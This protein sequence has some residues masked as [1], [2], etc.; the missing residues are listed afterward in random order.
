[1]PLL[2]LS[3]FN[4]VI[5]LLG[6][7]ITLFGLVSYLI[8]E[9]YYLSEAFLSLFA[10][11]LFK[12]TGL[13]KPLEYAGG[14]LE[15]LETVTL[16]FT[17]LVLGVQLV[18][19]G[20]QLPSRYLLK[21][22]RSLSLLLGPGMAGMWASTSLLVYLLVP[23]VSFL[24]ALAIGA[25]VTPTDPLLS[26]TILRG[27]FA[28]E[29]VPE[30]LRN[31]II[32]ESGANDGLGYTFLFLALYFWKYT[33]PS[34]ATDTIT[35]AGGGAHTALGHWMAETCLWVVLFSILYGWAVGWAAKELL[36]WAEKNKYVDRESFFVFA[37]A[38]SLFIVGTCG[39]LG[40]DDVLACFIAGNAFTWD[41]WFRVQT[42][43]D[44]LQ[45]TVDMLLNAAIFMW[46]GAICPW[47]TFLTL[48]LMPTWRLLALGV[49]V[50]LLRR[51]P[52]ILV[53]RRY[54]PQ[55]RELK[56]AAFVGYF[57][58]IGVSAIFYLYVTL[59]FLKEQTGHE[60]AERFGEAVKLVVWFLTICSIVVHGLSVPVGKLGYY[61]PRRR[62]TQAIMLPYDE[63]RGRRPS[64][65]S[66]IDP[67]S[68]S[69]YS[70]A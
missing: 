56:Q 53:L 62:S 67:R 22:W 69:D 7:W 40:T 20:V 42:K 13:I 51:L 65:A 43:D 3:N 4:I 50:L 35:V 12:V 41:D 57:G 45:P 54:V 17:R 16:N 8:K 63:R 26:N 30:P 66:S 55:F 24:Q 6:G 49:L 10:G 29:N 11:L 52:V 68:D 47:A 61:L 58:P 64:H 59:E 33:T 31:I 32:A 2:D 39:I 23:G 9:Q 15:N 25:C 37:I 21:E 5:S 60:D 27:K 46:L 34:S 1:M 70:D 36:H 19:A 18:L 48:D 28:D 38:L 44:S 14:S